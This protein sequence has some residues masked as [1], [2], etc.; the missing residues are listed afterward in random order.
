[1]P[2]VIR[3]VPAGSQTVA[4]SAFGSGV[5]SRRGRCTRKSGPVVRIAACGSPEATTADSASWPTSD[6]AS[7]STIRPGASDCAERSRPQ[8]AAAAGSV[9]SSSPVTAT[10]PRVTTTNGVADRASSA[11]HCRAWARARPTVSRAASCADCPAGVVRSR[12][13]APICPPATA[14]VTAGTSGCV[15]EPRVSQFRAAD[16]S[17]RAVHSTWWRASRS[18]ERAARSAS[19]RTG[20]T[21]TASATATVCPAGS[22][23]RTAYVSSASGSG[24]RWTCRVSAP[25]AY[26][27]RPRHRVTA[28]GRPG[29]RAAYRGCSA[30]SSSAGWR[31][32]PSAREAGSEGR[33]TSAKRSPS[34]RQALVRPW[35]GVP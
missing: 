22:V 4:S 14:A 1:M 33:V 27:R 21:V 16:G 15:A 34:R 18:R 28:C 30:A 3:T 25:V 11:S 23:R 20:P 6:S 26:R 5:R 2:P 8:A 24:A 32:K 31:P 17:G 19:A 7:T 35:Y 29:S 10:A 13:T 9:T 12:R